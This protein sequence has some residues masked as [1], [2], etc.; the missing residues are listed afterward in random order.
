MHMQNLE[1]DDCKHEVSAT[2]TD[3]HSG[4]MCISQSET[5]LSSCN[6]HVSVDSSGHQFTC[7]NNELI[8]RTTECDFRIQNIQEVDVKDA[9]ST[10]NTDSQRNMCSS[11]GTSQPASCND[12]V[13]ASD[14]DRRFACVICNKLVHTYRMRRHMQSHADD[15]PFS[16]DICPR[17]FLESRRLTEHMR[18]HSG[19]RPFA[20]YVCNRQF[21]RSG[22]LKGICGFTPA[23]NRTAARFA[24]C[25][26]TGRTV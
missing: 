17:K 22:N 8:P 15:R 1:E 9:V 18:S 25:S 11:H 23:R 19:E 26:S 6:A 21:G 3:S 7:A 5:Q 12:R 20:C 13:S 14:T 4:N 2:S 24:R 10:T 16:C